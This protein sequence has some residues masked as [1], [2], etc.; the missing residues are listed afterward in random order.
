VTRLALMVGAALMAGGGGVEPSPCGSDASSDVGLD[1]AD[2]GVPHCVLTDDAG[3]TL[4]LVCGDWSPSI[5]STDSV[6]CRREILLARVL[7][8]AGPL[9]K[10]GVWNR[11]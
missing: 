10:H 4:D 5:R 6:R 11:R 9:H 8:L 3:D 7:V 1:A 2:A